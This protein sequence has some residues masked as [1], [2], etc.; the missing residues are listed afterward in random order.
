MIVDQFL[1][2]RFIQFRIHG[3][4]ALSKNTWLDTNLIREIVRKPVTAGIIDQGAGVG[5]NVF[6]GSP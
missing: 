4:T 6:E 5:M 1:N 3:V 2:E